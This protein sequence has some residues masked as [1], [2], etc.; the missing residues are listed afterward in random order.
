MNNDNNDNA[1]NDSISNTDEGEA[2]DNVAADDDESAEGSDAADSD[3]AEDNS[4]NETEDDVD[5]ASSDSDNMADP[6]GT[7]AGGGGAGRTKP[8]IPTFTGEGNNIFEISS[9]TQEF[10]DSF[11][12]YCQHAR[13]TQDKRPDNRD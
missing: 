6:G 8:I 2:T 1:E 4:D 9:L 12:G 10:I 13:I 3:S 7:E 5:D 11:L